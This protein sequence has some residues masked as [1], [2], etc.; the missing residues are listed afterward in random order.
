MDFAV[1]LFIVTGSAVAIV[2]LLL[3][4]TSIKERKLRASVVSGTT[5]AVF[6]TLWYLAH[7]TALSMS[8]T[9]LVPSGAVIIVALLLF[10]PPGAA[11]QLRVEDSDERFDERD[12]LFSREEY[13]PG[14][15]K[16][17]AYYSV[18]PE[19]KDMDDRLRS[20][21]ELLKPGGRYFDPLISPSIDARFD[22]LEGLTDKVDGPVSSERTRVVDSEVTGL[23]KKMILSQ[24]AMAVGIA[25]MRQ[26]WVY[27]H[28]GRGPEPWGTS[29]VN[30][31]PYAIVF[32]VE[33]DYAGV[34]RAPGL[35]ITSETTRCYLLAAEISIKLAEYIRGLGYSARAHSAG[36][37][38]QI[39]MPAVAYGAGLGELGR[40]GYLI[41][42]E[43]GPRV[44]L[45]AVTSDLPLI[46][47]KPVSFG[48]QNFCDKCR[49]CAVNCPSGAIPTGD[50]VWVR[51]VEKWPL[52]AEACLRYWR[53]I[54]TDCGLCMKV[55]PYSHPDSAAHS[56]VRSAIRRSAIARTVSVYGDDLLYGKRIT[57]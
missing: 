48:V 45:G 1:L 21:P 36:S 47:D 28:V 26:S 29:I 27:S 40:I 50:K 39:I 23:V 52:A 24:G 4:Q 10:L 31:H 6:V 44:R 13:L 20:L 53:V 41:T 14:S 5:L 42:P 7:L 18:R 12:V 46:A 43:L 16:H 15:Y 25:K 2:L 37:N 51:G 56:L 3:L 8:W 19:H 34:E 30:S 49:K 54:G 32:T 38:Y 33:M 22:E 57:R 35:P 11:A 55:C 9:L 17:R